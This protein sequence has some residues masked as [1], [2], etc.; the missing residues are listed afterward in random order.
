MLLNIPNRGTFFIFAT[1]SLVATLF[2]IFIVPETSNLP[3][4]GITYVFERT[5]YMKNCVTDLSPRKRRETQ[6]FVISKLANNDTAV[7]EK[8]QAMP[9]PL[10]L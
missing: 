1:F 2:T 5:P 3:L 7:K 8:I 9:G 4:E 10:L 6:Q